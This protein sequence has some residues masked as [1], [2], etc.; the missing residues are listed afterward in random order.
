MENAFITSAEIKTLNA[1][2]ITAGTLS[3]DRLS[4]DGNTITVS[5]GELVVGD[6]SIG[7]SKISDLNASKIDAGT[8]SAERFIGSGIT[9]L[10]SAAVSVSAET[11]TTNLSVSIS[12][13][14]SGTKL[15]G[16]AGVS[17]RVTTNNGSRTFTTTAS[18]SGAGSSGSVATVNGVADNEGAAI[19]GWLGAVVTGTTTTAGTATLSVSIVRGTGTGNTSFSGSIV[20]LGVQS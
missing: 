14:Q 11:G 20:I 3:A 6:N 7:N 18:L 16:I 1:D 15:L 9:H 10:G 19:G 12:G 4:L 5:G 13:L 8:I 17:G 2:V